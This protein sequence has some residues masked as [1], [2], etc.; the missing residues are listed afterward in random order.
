LTEPEAQAI[1]NRE[2]IRTLF[3]GQSIPLGEAMKRTKA[4]TTDPDVRRTW[5]LSGDPTTRLKN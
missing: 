3:N 2:L 1:M 4:A 5:I